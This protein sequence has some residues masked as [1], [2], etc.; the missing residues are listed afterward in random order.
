MRAGAAARALVLT[1]LTTGCGADD[2]TPEAAPRPSAPPASDVVAERVTLPPPEPSLGGF[3]SL[4]LAFD[5][6]TLLTATR[7]TANVTHLHAFDRERPSRAIPLPPQVEGERPYGFPHLLAVEGDLAVVSWVGREREQLFVV[8]REGD[9]LRWG[10][11]VPL[12]AAFDPTTPSRLSALQL[13]RECL[14]VGAA[15]ANGSAGAVLVLR[16]TG[17]RF[18]P[19]AY[20]RTPRPDS[21]AAF[22]DAIALDGDRLV[23]GAPRVD[24]LDGP[25][26]TDA[27]AYVYRR[28]SAG[29]QLEA[30]LAPDEPEPGSG[31][32]DAVAI[33]GA[34]VMVGAPMVHRLDARP[35]YP[36]ESGA[37]GAVYLYR[38][39]GS[40]YSLEAV[41]Q[42]EGLGPLAFFGRELDAQAGRLVVGAP[43]SRT[44]RPPRPGWVHVYERCEDAW[45]P[46]APIAGDPSRPGDLFG[47]RVALAAR[48][49]AVG[50]PEAPAVG[51]AQPSTAGSVSLLRLTRA[52]GASTPTP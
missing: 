25:P 23:V 39:S 11:E 48:W 29:W 38:R 52:C 13:T 18:G 7:D 32:G 28:E 33:T 51:G 45:V 24:R 22:G 21:D 44:T 40:A 16:R 15:S 9:A 43:S 5:G 10:D 27:R 8:Q 42:P 36:A 49:L 50:A 1:L 19:P 14:V 46:L 31:F 17:S 41:L 2:A 12:G 34:H 30:E 47:S 26:P 3:F 37:V 4:P 35:P 6:D 20:L